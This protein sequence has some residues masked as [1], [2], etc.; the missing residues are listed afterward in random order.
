[1]SIDLASDRLKYYLIQNVDTMTSD[2]RFFKLKVGKRGEIYTTA[3]LRE[4]LKLKPGSTVLAR[5]VDEGKMLVEVTP[6]IEELLKKPKKVKLS[7]EDVEKLSFEAQREVGL[8][9]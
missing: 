3:E 5:I 4:A 7:V 1:M 8:V 2:V 9:E 6:T